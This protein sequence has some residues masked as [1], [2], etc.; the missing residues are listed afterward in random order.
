MDLF[1]LLKTIE[2]YEASIIGLH[3]LIDPNFLS[4]F[5]NPNRLRL[6]ESKI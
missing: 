4:L 6:T 5:S 2:L 1:I 3:D